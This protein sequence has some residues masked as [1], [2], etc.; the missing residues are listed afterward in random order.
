MRQVVQ[1][2][3]AIRGIVLASAKATFFA[4]ADLK[5]TLRLQPADAPTVFREIEAVK[6]NFRLLETLGERLALP[7]FLEPR[8]AA[9]EAG[10]KPLS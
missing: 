8:R 3:E 10:L 4:G 6:K 9:I 1:E 2:R 5:G 7:P